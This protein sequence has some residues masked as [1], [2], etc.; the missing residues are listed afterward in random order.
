MSNT[1]EYKGYIGSI[2]FSE[3]DAIFCGKVLGIRALISYEGESAH[4]LLEDFHGAVDDYLALCLATGEEP[5]KSYKGTFNVRIS[6]ELH[7]KAA[8]AAMSRKMSL[9]SFVENSIASAVGTEE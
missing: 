9:N 1:M 8:I 7:K 3:A 6:P 5:E 2:E 4:E